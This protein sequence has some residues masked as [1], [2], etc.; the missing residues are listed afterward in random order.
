MRVG[1]GG[2]RIEP[3]GRFVGHAS[4]VGN[5][6]VHGAVTLTD[7]AEEGFIPRSLRLPVWHTRHFPDLAGGGPLV[8][9]L[10]RNLISGFEL[11][12]VWQGDAELEFLASEFEEHMPLAPVE[13]LGGF[14][15]AVAFTITGAEVRS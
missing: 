14:K 10:A 6:V 12:D 7:P 5:K 2:P 1:Q 8:H 3:G 11:A 15:C 9:D 13:V 4:S